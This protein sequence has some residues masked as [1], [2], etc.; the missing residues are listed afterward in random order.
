MYADSSI[1][2]KFQQGVRLT[3]G[4][5]ALGCGELEVHASVVSFAP[6]HLLFTFHHSLPFVVRGPARR[7]SGGS[8][9]VLRAIS[10][11]GN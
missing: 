4:S 3:V 1:P 5:S 2:Y 6:S 10:H 8:A 11:C 7:L 9:F